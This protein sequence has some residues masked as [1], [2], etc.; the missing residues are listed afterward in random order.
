M[1]IREDFFSERAVLHWHRQPRLV[2]EPSSLEVFKNCG[3]VA[4]RD[5]A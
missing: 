4:V 2:I 5:M 1:D 3:N